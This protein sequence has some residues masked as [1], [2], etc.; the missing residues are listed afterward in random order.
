MIQVVSD[1][2]HYVKNI[3]TYI[4][5]SPYKTSFFREKLALSKPTF[6]RKM[7]EGTF[8]MDEIDTITK[9]LYPREAILQA[10]RKSEKDI[11]QGNVYTHEEALQL[12]RRQYAS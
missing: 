12:L 11:E 4:N 8:T 10:L 3:K 9:L 5:D 2:Q 1:Y 6:Y 7:R